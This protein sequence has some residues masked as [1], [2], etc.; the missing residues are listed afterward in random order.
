MGGLDTEKQ[1]NMTDKTI[2]AINRYCDRYGDKLV[3]LMNR[4]NVFRLPDVP[5]NKA[6]EYLKEL[7][8]KN[9]GI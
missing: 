8:E 9:L 3:E 5:E 6:L 2:N 4:C 1:N 7:E